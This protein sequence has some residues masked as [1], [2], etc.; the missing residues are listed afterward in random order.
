MDGKNR[1]MHKW[2]VRYGN[3]LPCHNTVVHLRKKAAEQLYE[4]YATQ[5][6][7]V[8]LCKFTYDNE[9]A[10]ILRLTAAQ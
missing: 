5:Y 8:Q 3:T 4:E 7:Y 9:H 6:T 10:I 1:N 2:F